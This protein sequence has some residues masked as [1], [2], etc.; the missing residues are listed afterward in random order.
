MKRVIL[1]T[2]V[3]NRICIIPARA[4]SKGLP[5]KNIRPFRGLPLLA[6]SVRHA[7]DSR[8]FKTIVVTS[9]SNRYLQIAQEA[10]AT[11]LIQ[12]PAELASD[13]AGSMEV[14]LHALDWAETETRATFETVCLLQPTSPLREPEHIAAVVEKLETSDLDSV[15]AVMAAKAS[16]YFT[17][18]ELD[19]GGQ[20]VSLS[21]PSTREIDH[22]QDAPVV[23]QITGSVYAWGARALRAQRG[24]LCNRT[25]IVEIPRLNSIDIDD[26][27]DWAFAELAADL[28]E[29]RRYPTELATKT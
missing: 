8:L 22:R 23:Y 18:V 24:V 17:L 9:D 11:H 7:L 20:T 26:A 16:P 27:D 6:H 10:G 21:K 12:R 5:H 3:P 28:L 13:T 19:P 29:A 4:G 15:I 2:S 1:L 14:L 25:G